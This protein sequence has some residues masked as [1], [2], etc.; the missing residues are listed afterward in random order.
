MWPVIAAFAIVLAQ[1]AQPGTNS[2]SE[3]WCFDR[4]QDAQLCEATENAC[5]KLRDLNTEIAKSPCKRVE[6]PVLLT[7][8]SRDILSCCCTRCQPL[9]SW[10]AHRIHWQWQ[11]R[12]GTWHGRDYQVAAI[13]ADGT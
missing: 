7:H 4:G 6:P 8:D 1:A 9:S 2:K 13:S 3:K 11:E 12:S 10:G 5:N